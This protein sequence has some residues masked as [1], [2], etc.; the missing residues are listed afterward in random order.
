MLS[1]LYAASAVVVIAPTPVAA[2]SPKIMVG[3]RTPDTIVDTF[4]KGLQAG[5]TSEAVLGVFPPVMAEKKRGDLDTLAVQIDSYLRWY[6]EVEG[7]DLVSEDAAT[8][9]FK[10]RIYLM[11]TLNGPTFWTIYLYRGS[12]G[13]VATGVNMSDVASVLF[14]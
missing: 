13:W 9:Y 5:K 8:P 4:F 1:L 14:D 11:R 3:E 2:P 6:G 7:W 12:S 10:R